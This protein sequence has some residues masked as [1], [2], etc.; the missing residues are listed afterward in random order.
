LCPCHTMITPS[1]L[2]RLSYT[3]DLTESGIAYACRSLA[4]TAERTGV[5]QMERLRLNVADVA[6]ELVFRR[7][8]SEQSIPFGVLGATPFTHPELYAV[9]L[10]GHRCE[11]KNFLITSRKQITHIRRDPS[12]LLQAP[13]LIPLDEFAAESHKPDDLYLFAFLLGV[14]AVA[15]EDEQ[16]ALAAGLSTYLI[17]P[18]PARWAH[19]ATWN[20]LRDLALKSDCESPISVEIGGQNADREFKTI[21]QELPSKKRVLV[22]HQFHSLA[23][24][25]AACRPEARIGL[26]SPARGD[27]YVVA[28]VEWGN[29]WFY[30]MDI[31]LAGWLSHEDYRR[32]GK[33]LNA[34]MRTLQC[35]H[36]AVKNLQVLVADLNPLGPLFERVRY[37]EDARRTTEV[38]RS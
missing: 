21:T 9:S 1:D 22:E 34:G 16:R 7:F 17:H 35:E 30:G 18:L 31:F 5:S 3:P 19:P 36:T 37:W 15:R 27:P 13:A 29:I 26:H 20:P 4:S 6:S 10:G 25:H 14:Q 32:K 2:V 28:P 23:Y 38:H 12:L 33:V 8:L 11:L 24:I